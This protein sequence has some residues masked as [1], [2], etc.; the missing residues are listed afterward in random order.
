MSRQTRS[1]DKWRIAPI[2][3]CIRWFPTDC[4]TISTSGGRPVCNTADLPATAFLQLETRSNGRSNGHLSP[5]LEH[6]QRL[7]QPPMEPSGKS[8][9][10]G[11]GT[12]ISRPDLSGANMAV[13]ALV[14]QTP[15]T[16]GG[17]PT[18]N[19]PPRE[20][21]SGRGGATPGTNP[22][23][24]R[25]AYLRQCYVSQQISGEATNLLLSSWRQKS[26]QSYDSLCKKWISWCSERQADPVSGPIEDVV[27]FL[28]HL[29][30][31]GY[32]YRS[33]NS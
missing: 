20:G 8:I 22:A 10:K 28:A 7:C 30:G 4:G 5:E 24:S 18:N 14:S 6:S 15:G 16:T 12:G 26:S 17:H 33:L 13:T 11:R 32:Q 29:H 23:P 21:N 3:C 31:D 19:R 27:N 25:V 2:G 9:G 1:R